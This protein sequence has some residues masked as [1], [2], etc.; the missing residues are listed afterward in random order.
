[1][2]AARLQFPVRLDSW[3]SLKLSKVL[4][5]HPWLEVY[6][7][8][9]ELPDG[10]VIDDFYRIVL[11]DFAIIVPVTKAGDLVMVRSYK[12]GLGRVSLCAPAG[13]VN[14]GESP[15]Q[16]AQ[17]ELIEETGYLA[18]KWQSLG[19][20]VVDGNR[21]CGRASIFLARDAYF[22]RPPNNPDPNEVV[23]PQLVTPSEFFQAIGGGDV[24]LLSTVG[25]V[26]LAMLAENRVENNPTLTRD[27]GKP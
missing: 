2:T 9:V 21:Q 15:L 10:R 25:A 16:A 13:F 7:E 18:S 1:M 17:R 23:E 6:R 5:A 26:C 19:N 22:V 14:P 24:A 12:H 20:F 8:R 27:V 11:P 3:K 4:S